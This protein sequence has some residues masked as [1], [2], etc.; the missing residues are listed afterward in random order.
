M[1]KTLLFVILIMPFWS[2]AQT[3]NSLPVDE[4]VFYA[5]TKQVNQFSGGLT[6]RKM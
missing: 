4:S 5:Q 1:K 3:Y 2:E 6:G